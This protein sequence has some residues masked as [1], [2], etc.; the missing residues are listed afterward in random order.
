VAT[1]KLS[2]NSSTPTDIV[3]AHPE[4]QMAQAKEWA[5]T[6][7]RTIDSNPKFTEMLGKNKYLKVE[8]WQMI[9]K[10]ARLSIATTTEPIREKGEIVGYKSIARLVDMITGDDRGAA[11]EQQCRLDSDVQKGQH[12]VDKKHTAVMGMAQTRASSRV[13]RENY[14]F[15]ALLGGFEPLTAEEITD[16]MR[17]AGSS[18]IVQH[19]QAQGANIVDVIPNT[20][21]NQ[22][23]FD[24]E[25]SLN[26][27]ASYTVSDDSFQCPLHEGEGT[28]QTKKTSKAGAIFWSHPD[29]GKWCAANEFN[30]STPRPEI[31][32]AWAQNLIDEMGHDSN[33]L[34][35][36]AS[37]P[38]KDWLEFMINAKSATM[39]EE[40]CVICGI[41]ADVQAEDGAWYCIPHNN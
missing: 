16:D 29:N 34:S 7:I 33:M 11:A 2:L 8:A 9:A 35:E 23:I 15:V 25:P 10:F 6:L 21:A 20:P 36:C 27:N 39:D 28:T 30:L 19:A 24:Q 4:E 13:V 1:D 3:L 41:K 40:W 37:K 32:S 38:I 18:P 17:I 14:A 31:A 12:T 5:T 26:S 22:N